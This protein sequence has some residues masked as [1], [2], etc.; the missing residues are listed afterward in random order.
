MRTWE[1]ALSAHP[2]ALDDF[3][4]HLSER[5]VAKL[6]ALLDTD[7][8]RDYVQ[9]Y[10]NALRDSKTQLRLNALE[11]QQRARRTRNAA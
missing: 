6:R 9:G 10:V 8:S 11:E 2:G 1:T 7:V 3:Y 4:A 5:E